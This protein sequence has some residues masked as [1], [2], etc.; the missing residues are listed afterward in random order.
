MEGRSARRLVSN[1]AKASKT[2]G[3]RGGATADED[4]VDDGD[5]GVAEDASTEATRLAKSSRSGTTQ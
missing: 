5:E 3:S 4:A 2:A 1:A